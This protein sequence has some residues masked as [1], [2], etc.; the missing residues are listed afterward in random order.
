MPRLIFLN[1]EFGGR[2][3]ELPEGKTTVGRG[4]EN[5]L[6]IRDESISRV[7]CE[8][9]VHGGEVIVRDL[10]SS[11]GTFVAAK[12]LRN[13]QAQ[14]ISGQIVQF[15][16]IRTRLDLGEPDF[17]D[18]ATDITTTFGVLKHERKAAMPAGP[19][20]GFR[21]VFEPDK[22][23]A[24]ASPHDHTSVISK[25]TPIETVDSSAGH[26]T[27]SCSDTTKL[28]KGGLM[29]IVVACVA[30]GLVV[31]LWALFLRE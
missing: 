4:S 11:N 16:A 24:A 14:A 6:A 23:A 10:G 15:G 19:V 9:L 27:D 31:L 13:Q 12:R 30:M 7:H 28:Q 26:E 29:W 21:E 5:D 3:H 20:E 22:P 2:A 17:S 25:P 8:I 18:T 1:P